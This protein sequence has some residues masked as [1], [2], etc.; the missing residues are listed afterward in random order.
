M[1]MTLLNDINKGVY[2]F[3]PSLIQISIKTMLK[4]CK[5]SMYRIC[6][7]LVHEVIE[8]HLQKHLIT[9]YSHSL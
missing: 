3:I 1:F 4:V 2:G 8:I 7:L 5:Y 9:P 6:K